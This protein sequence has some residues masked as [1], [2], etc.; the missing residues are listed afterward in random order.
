VRP[1]T[2]ITIALCRRVSFVKSNN[3]QYSQ[4]WNA[5]SFRHFATWICISQT[6]ARTITYS[7]I[8]SCVGGR[9]KN[10][11]TSS[12][13]TVFQKHTARQICELFEQSV[14]PLG[15]PVNFFTFNRSFNAADLWRRDGATARRRDGARACVLLRHFTLRKQRSFTLLN[16][17]QNTPNM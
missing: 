17:F 9:S 4:G 11:N 12:V 8:S 15:F 13:R 1:I 2:F 16:I 5:K 10:V 3:G 7:L 14:V 6:D